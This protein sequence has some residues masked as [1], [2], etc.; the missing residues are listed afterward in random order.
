MKNKFP[1]V[2][3]FYGGKEIYHDLL[4]AGQQLQKILIQRNII[5]QLSQDF[6]YLT[7]EDI[8]NYDA[9]IFYTQEKFIEKGGGF[10]PLHAT[11]VFND[12]SQQ[13]LLNL[14]GCKFQHHEPF[15]RFKIEISQN[16]FITRDL[17]DFIINDELYE[18]QIVVP[19][20]KILARA[21]HQ[22]KETS[23][24]QLVIRNYGQGRICYLAPG[25]DGRSWYHPEFQKLL[26]RA[27]LW[28]CGENKSV[29][30]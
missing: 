3:I 18:S 10:L 16:H 6:S 13:K 4:A 11:S 19:P 25:H 7:T 26:Y 30:I 29:I 8:N 24:P 14:V 5:A 21:Q 15:T 1:K 2:L 27:T 12:Y 23:H 20:D 9:L 22:Q 17:D 28:V